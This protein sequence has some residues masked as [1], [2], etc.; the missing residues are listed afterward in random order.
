MKSIW[1]LAEDLDRVE[2]GLELIGRQYQ[3]PPV[4]R[5]DLLCRDPE[6][7]FVVIEIK[8]F[9]AGA[10]SIVD[11]IARY[12]TWTRQ[13]LA[14]PGQNVRGIIIVGKADERLAYAARAISGLSVKCLD[15]ALRECPL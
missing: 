5:I 10:D 6:G 7:C 2:P 14:R 1:K 15:L 9:R 13:N 8:K 3:A 4:G 11:Q 12:L